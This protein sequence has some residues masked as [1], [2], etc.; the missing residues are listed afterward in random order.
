LQ[1]LQS[2]QIEMVETIKELVE[3]E[4]PSDSKLAVDRL[5]AFMA[6]KFER[7]SGRVKFHHQ[8]EYGDHLQVDFAGGRSRKPILLLGHHD[9]VWPLGTLATMP[10]AVHDGRIWGP[11]S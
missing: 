8:T 11:G 10:C 4:S 1:V 6:G 2:Q 7:A 9:T 3:I 5:G